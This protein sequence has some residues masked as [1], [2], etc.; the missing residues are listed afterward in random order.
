MDLIIF[1]IALLIHLFL[2]VVV[3]AVII[4]GGIWVV[5]QIVFYL[6]G[7]EKKG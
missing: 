1:G 4:A 7:V 6:T 5:S 3:A 2:T